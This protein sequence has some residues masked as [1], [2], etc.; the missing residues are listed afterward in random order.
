MGMGETATREFQ[1]DASWPSFPAGTTASVGR[2]L[3]LGLGNDI[4]R[5][6]A[7]GLRVAGAVRRRLEGNA[8]VDVIEVCE[9]GLALL[10]L[11]VGYERLVIVDSIQT[12]Q[13]Q[14]GTIHVFDASQ[15]KTRR[16]GAPHFLGV[17]ETLALGRHLGLDMPERVEVIA[18]EVEDPFTLG[19]ELTPAVVRAVEPAV[20]KVIECLDGC[21]TRVG[22]R[23]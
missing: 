10:D 19:T 1:E 18:V 5:D 4:L 9:M 3:V 11:I 17:G 13:S 6:D 21:V 16:N 7:V 23:E 20:A 2:T 8:T 12:G 15:V 14:P 22:G